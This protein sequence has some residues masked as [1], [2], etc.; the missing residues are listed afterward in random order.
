MYLQRLS[1]AGGG[2]V[3]GS[4]AAGQ[5]L[6][7]PAADL[8]AW[9]WRDLLHLV[10]LTAAQQL[11]P[12]QTWLT[13]VQS[14]L[15]PKLVLVDNAKQL[16]EVLQVRKRAVMWAHLPEQLKRKQGKGPRSRFT[17]LH[18]SSDPLFGTV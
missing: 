9:S 2:L 15:Q 11:A 6:L 8:A 14:A 10:E 16:V 17:L 13:A 12:S 18:P 7:P 5:D 3:Q 1:A 4:T